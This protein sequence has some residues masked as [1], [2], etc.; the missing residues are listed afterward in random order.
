MSTCSV[1]QG[2]VNIFSGACRCVSDEAF[3]IVDLRP[4]E[5]RHKNLSP[6]ICG[7]DKRRGRVIVLLIIIGV[8]AVLTESAAQHI[9]V[10]EVVPVALIA[11]LVAGMDGYVTKLSTQGTF[12]RPSSEYWPRLAP[13]MQSCHALVVAQR[14]GEAIGT[15]RRRAAL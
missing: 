2:S 11:G 12:S 7:G 5:F 3:L 15:A 13:G 10:A 8:L 6:R 9:L 14:L 1:G 4:V